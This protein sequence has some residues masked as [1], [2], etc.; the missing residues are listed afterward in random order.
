MKKLTREE[1]VD[2]LIAVAEARKLF[3]QSGITN[4]ITVA[5]ELYQELIATKERALVL[6]SGEQQA[7]KGPGFQE[8]EI[9]IPVDIELEKPS[10]PDCGESLNLRQATPDE[11]EEG[12]RSAWFCKKCDFVGQSEKSVM[13]WIRELP[14]KGAEEVVVESRVEK[15]DLPAGQ[16]MP[17]VR[18][19]DAEKT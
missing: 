2:R 16:T 10:C 19:A 18:E 11:I 1:F 7:H 17:S 5:F 15:K 4:N 8:A 9:T 12:F 3:I 6:D 13:R 14:E